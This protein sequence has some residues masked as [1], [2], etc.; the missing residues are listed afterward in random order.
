MKK[1]EEGKEIRKMRSCNFYFIIIIRFDIRS[2]KYID[3]VTSLD[4]VTLIYWCHFI[5]IFMCS[6]GSIY[7]NDMIRLLNLLRYVLYFK[8]DYFMFF[9]YCFLNSSCGSHNVTCGQVIISLP[10]KSKV[11]LTYLNDW[12]KQTSHFNDPI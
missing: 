7:Y 6:Y 5:F 4:Y 8:L 1:N 12:S 10:R 2:H 11:I 9:L 3:E